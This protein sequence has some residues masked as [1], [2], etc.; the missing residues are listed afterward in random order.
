VEPENWYANLQTLPT[1][2][3]N[4]YPIWLAAFFILLLV[5]IFIRPQ[6]PK[7]TIIAFLLPSLFTFLMMYKSFRVNDLL[8]LAA[9]SGMGL[10]VSWCYFSQRLRHKLSWLHK[11][12]PTVAGVLSAVILINSSVVTSAAGSG[13]LQS[14]EMATKLPQLTA[15]GIHVAFGYGVFTPE[16]ALYYAN[17]TSKDYALDEIVS[18]F[19]NW[20]DYNIWNSMFYGFNS[21]FRYWMPCQ[22]LSGIVDSPQG[23]LWVPG[24]DLVPT[25][26]ND[27]YL[28][29]KYSPIDQ[30]GQFTVYKVNK[31]ICRE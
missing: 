9:L 22:E 14:T 11:G 8:V 3:V 16:T 5:F 10:A 1:A 12:L 29:M 20:I 19:P 21:E 30:V 26:P 24:R 17:Q 27:Q 28:L 31:I 6:I 13:H 25:M 4:L 15:E 7:R 23:L 2:L 18:S